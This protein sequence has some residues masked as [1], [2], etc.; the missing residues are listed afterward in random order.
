M[1]RLDT[2]VDELDGGAQDVE[3]ARVVQNEIA[4]RHRFHDSARLDCRHECC[5]DAELRLHVIAREAPSDGIR[6]RHGF[7][8]RIRHGV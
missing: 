8:Y 2:E 5:V 7:E 1:T 4:H 6:R 3:V